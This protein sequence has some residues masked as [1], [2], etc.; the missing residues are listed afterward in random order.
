MIIS[1]PFILNIIHIPPCNYKKKEK[2]E[3]KNSRKKFTFHHVSI[4]T[5]LCPPVVFLYDHSHS[6]MYLLKPLAAGMTVI[7]VEHSHSTMYLLKRGHILSASSIQRNS[8]STMYLLKRE[9]PPLF[10]LPST[11][12]H[13]TMYLL[14]LRL[15]C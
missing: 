2:I 1:R 12:S 13:S 11:Y 14:K 15:M 3:E 10:V 6:T 9:V 4:K 5:W 7:D 8:H